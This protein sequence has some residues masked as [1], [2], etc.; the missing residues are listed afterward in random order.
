MHKDERLDSQCAG[1]VAVLRI[2]PQIP[3]G[4][5]H[6]ESGVVLGFG[7]EDRLEGLVT[8]HEVALLDLSLAPEDGAGVPG[9]HRD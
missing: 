1:G 2:V 5:L 6:T 7:A 4:E 3:E 9:A 8:G